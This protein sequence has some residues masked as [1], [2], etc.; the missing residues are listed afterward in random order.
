MQVRIHASSVAFAALSFGA[1]GTQQM[2]AATS[3][4][5]V[6]ENLM[7]ACLCREDG[8]VSEAETP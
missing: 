3:R 4:S 2:L 6:L 8:W 5:V 7:L 1:A